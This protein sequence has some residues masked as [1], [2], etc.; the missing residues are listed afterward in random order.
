MS[1][2]SYTTCV[3]PQNVCRQNADD[4]KLNYLTKYLELIDTVF[5]VLKKKPLSM[6]AKSRM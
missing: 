4:V 3:K 6:L 2:S 5:L 1:W